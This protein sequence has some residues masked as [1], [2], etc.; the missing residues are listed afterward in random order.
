MD[1]SEAEAKES[2]QQFLAELKEKIQRGE[3]LDEHEQKAYIELELLD[4]EGKL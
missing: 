4:S 3:T 1:V 2:M